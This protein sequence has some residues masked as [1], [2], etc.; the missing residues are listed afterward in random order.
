[1]RSAY[2]GLGAA[3]LLACGGDSNGP[4]AVLLAGQYDSDLFVAFSNAFEQQQGSE[5]GA[6]SLS[7]Q[8]WAGDFAGSYVLQDGSSGTIAGN[9]RADGGITISQFGNANVSPLASLL[10][11]QNAYP[12]CNWPTAGT[13]GSPVRSPVPPLRSVVRRHCRVPTV[14]KA[15]RCTRQ[16]R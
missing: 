16:P 9:V 6:I 15:E 5:S 4:S 12:N 7:A 3:F 11:L 8:N 2:L 14:R 13:T 1:V 10:F